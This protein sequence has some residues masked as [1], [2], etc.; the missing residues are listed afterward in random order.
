M[1][2]FISFSDSTVKKHPRVTWYQLTCDVNKIILPFYLL[3][4]LWVLFVSVV[5]MQLLVRE[6]SMLLLIL[7]F[8]KVHKLFFSQNFL[9]FLEQDFMIMQV[10]LSLIIHLHKA[11]VICCPISFERLLQLPNHVLRYISQMGSKT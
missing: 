10:E 4:F 2:S 9:S 7:P 1:C 6:N 3:Y 11:K 8:M 5:D